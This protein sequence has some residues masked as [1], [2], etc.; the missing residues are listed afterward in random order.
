MK[1]VD[2]DAYMADWRRRVE[3]GQLTED[4]DSDP[5]VR[6]K[7][8]EYAESGNLYREQGTTVRG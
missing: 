8:P 4:V 2:Y 1:D 3:S 7:E 5:S 6:E